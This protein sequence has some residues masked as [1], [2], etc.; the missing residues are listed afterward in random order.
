MRAPG[1]HSPPNDSWG[2]F[3][4]LAPKGAAWIID[5]K[6]ARLHPVVLRSLRAPL[7]VELVTAGEALKSTRALE[8]IAPKLLALP[9]GGTLVAVG[10]GTVGDFATV[11]AHLVKRGVELVQVPTTLLAAVD[12]SV[13]GKGALNVGAVKNALG[14]FHYA[15]KTLLCAEFFETLSAAQHREGIA[16]ALKMAVCLDAGVWKKWSRRA[17]STLELVKTARRLKQQVCAVDPYEQTGRRSVLNF[18]HTFG[19]VIEGLSGFRVRHGEAVALG[20]LC[21]LDV[22][23]AMEV[24]PSALAEEVEAVLTERTGASRRRLAAV[25]ERHSTDEVER[26]LGADKKST[27]DGLRMVLLQRPGVARLVKVPRWR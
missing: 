27:A 7:Q 4:S 1:S 22:G 24:T 6:V 12:S 10:G 11:A 26:L 18:G 15:A 19:H 16:E 9:R 2:R 20:M 8:R 3:A 13:G 14:V 17:P 5:A 21:A 23:R 25:L